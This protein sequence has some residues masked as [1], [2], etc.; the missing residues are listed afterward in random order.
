V[1]EAMPEPRRPALLFD[2]LGHGASA[3][4]RDGY[5]VERQAEL[6]ARELE[7][8]EVPPVLFVGHSVGGLIGTALAAQAPEHVAGLVLVDVPPNL[9]HR[10]MTLLARLS[11]LPVVGAASW[12]FAPDAVMA[13]GMRLVVAPGYSVPRQVVR[14]SRAMS[15][16]SA[17]LTAAG[18]EDYLTRVDVVERVR[19]AGK[20]TLV[21][22]GEEEQYFPVAAARE[23]ESV[24]EV[25]TIPGAGHTA[26]LE[27]PEEVARAVERFAA[28]LAAPVAHD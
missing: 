13:F 17:R 3:A 20:P 25:V 7:D 28:G 5:S 2:L 26:Y 12:R 27:K 4:P 15:H 21:L 24:A 23:F 1:L 10:R 8:R 16:R 18:V 9:K 22:W 14:E 19:E 11:L 6:V